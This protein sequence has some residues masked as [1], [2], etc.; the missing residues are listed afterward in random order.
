MKYQ[1]VTDCTYT[2]LGCVDH[3]HQLLC[4]VIYLDLVVSMRQVEFREG[5]PTSE[6]CENVFNTR[7]GVSLHLGSLIRGQ[8]IV[9]AYP[10]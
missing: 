3:H 4:L 6:G 7:E 9:A 10:Y 2:S 5:F 1:M 8:L